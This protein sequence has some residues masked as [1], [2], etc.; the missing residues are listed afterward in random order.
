MSKRTTML[1]YGDKTMGPDN[2][3]PTPGVGSYTFNNEINPEKNMRRS[4]SFGVS[5]EVYLL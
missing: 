4:I 1:G 5:R 3:T 2:P